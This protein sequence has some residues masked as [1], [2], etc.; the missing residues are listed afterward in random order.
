MIPVATPFTTNRTDTNTV[1]VS[2]AA[3]VEAGVADRVA[4]LADNARV[5]PMKPLGDR[6]KAVQINGAQALGRLGLGRR[7]ALIDP[8]RVGQTQRRRRG[9]NAFAQIGGQRLMRSVLHYPPKPKRGD[10][11][12]IVSP[13]SGLPSLFPMPYELGLRR[14]RDDLDL[15]PVEYPT[16]RR[17]DS[18]PADRAADLH[19]AFL[20]PTI[21]AII[22]SIGGDNQIRVLPH[23]DRDL[24]SANPKPFFGY[25]D[26]TNLLIYLWNAGIVGYHGGS[27]MYHLGRP[28]ALHSVTRASFEAALFEGGDYLLH[29]PQ[30]YGDVDLSWSDPLTFERERPSEPAEPWT[31]LNADQVV[32]GI[33]WGGNLEVLSWLA[34]ADIGFQA[35]DAYAGCVLMIETSEE[36]PSASDVYRVLRSFGE[37]GVLGQFAAVLVGRAKAW[38][39]ARPLEAEE[40]DAYRRAQREAVIQAFDFTAA[41]R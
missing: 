9:P 15:V 3:S 38:S 5:P 30:S 26:N 22:T 12:A 31:W 10:R 4:R 27:V 7:V 6:L 17:I 39:F 13:S 20:D 21:T 19:A 23:L 40:K 16:T 33:T 8:S 29:E 37:R 28:T 35:P 32:D 18:T 25:S 34:M 2:I 1:P 11:V 41:A 24:I 14:L 36:M